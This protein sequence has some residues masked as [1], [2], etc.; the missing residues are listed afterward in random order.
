MT[1]SMLLLVGAVA[2]VLA[3]AE[4]GVGVANGILDGE[5]V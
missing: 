1:R 4:N 5:D 2:V 3:V